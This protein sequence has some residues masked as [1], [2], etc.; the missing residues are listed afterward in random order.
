MHTTFVINTIYH[1][2]CY[3]PELA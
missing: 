1:Y 3:K 2:F